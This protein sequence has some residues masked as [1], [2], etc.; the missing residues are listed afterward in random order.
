MTP[1]RPPLITDYR[2][3][4]ADGSVPL[5]HDL[6]VG[7]GQRPGCWMPYNL[8]ATSAAGKG[9]WAPRRSR[10]FRQPRLLTKSLPVVG[11]RA[12]TLAAHHISYQPEKTAARGFDPWRDTQAH[13]PW[14][15]ERSRNDGLNQ[16]SPCWNLVD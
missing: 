15:N 7:Q 1:S 8:A 13:P 10:R 11:A 16:P 6:R 9:F 3:W 2:R 4:Q 14:P 12:V 5:E